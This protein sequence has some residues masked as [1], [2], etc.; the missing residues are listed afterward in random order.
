MLDAPEGEQITR[1][2]AYFDAGHLGRQLAGRRA[3]GPAELMSQ[4]V[5][6]AG[7]LTRPLTGGPPE[8]AAAQG[9]DV[10]RM[11]RARHG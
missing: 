5:A 3:A 6:A 7:L 8:E 2:R 1:F 4:K 11:M 9:L 10:S